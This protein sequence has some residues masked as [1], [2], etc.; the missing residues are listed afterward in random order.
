MMEDLE[1]ESPTVR[2][3]NS[4]VVEL[5]DRQ[6]QPTAPGAWRASQPIIRRLLLSIQAFSVIFANLTNTD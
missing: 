4:I 2:C 6:P 1:K 3:H 5:N